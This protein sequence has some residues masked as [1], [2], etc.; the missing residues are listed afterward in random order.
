MNDRGRSS[1]KGAKPVAPVRM[2][3]CLRAGVQAPGMRAP[4]YDRLTP[5]PGAARQRLGRS[6]PSR[7]FVP[8]VFQT[9]P[10]LSRSVRYRTTRASRP[11]HLRLSHEARAICYG[12]LGIG[13]ARAHVGQPRPGLNTPASR[14]D[15]GGPVRARASEIERRTSNRSNGSQGTYPCIFLTISSPSSAVMAGTMVMLNTSSQSAVVAM[16]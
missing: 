8:F 10:R 6:Y 4:A 3:E 13:P 16:S 12:G 11:D 15:L 14:R 7:R 2:A 1:G 9:S 5:E